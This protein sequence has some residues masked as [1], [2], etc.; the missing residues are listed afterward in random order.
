MEKLASES[1][2]R[3]RSIIIGKEEAKTLFIH[4]WHDCLPD[5]IRHSTE[6]LLGPNKFAK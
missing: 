4:S 2:K 1:R 5:N 6:K 3:I